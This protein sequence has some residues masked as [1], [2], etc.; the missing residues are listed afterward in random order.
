[1]NKSLIVKIVG[2]VSALIFTVGALLPIA[3]LEFFGTK[4]SKSL[5]DNYDW[6]FVVLDAVLIII[7]LLLKEEVSLDICAAT[8]VLITAAE[9]KPFFD[10]SLGEAAAFITKGIGF[11]CL[12]IGAVLIVIVSIIQWFIPSPEN[13]KKKGK[14]PDTKKCPYCAEMIK[15]EAIICRY[16]GSRLDQIEYKSDEPLDEVDAF[17]AHS[18]VEAA[19]K[20]AGRIFLKVVLIIVSSLLF[21]ICLLGPELGLD[22]ENSES[23]ISQEDDT[24]ATKKTSLI[25]AYFVLNGKDKDDPDAPYIEIK[26]DGTF[27]LMRKTERERKIFLGKWECIS[28]DSLT[29]FTLNIQEMMASDYNREVGYPLSN[30][31]ITLYYYGDD[32]YITCEFDYDKDPDLLGEIKSGSQLYS[33]YYYD[34]NA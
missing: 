17:D 29:T 22:K 6:I 21:G 3:S 1:M 15:A 31:P 7:N 28:T 11:Y 8:A 30:V 2:I 12:I 9:L 20:S 16:C 5:I 4:I 32:F 33:A 34:M 14:E 23:E 10:G 19:A 13:T 24:T 27:E 18:K 26:S 25:H